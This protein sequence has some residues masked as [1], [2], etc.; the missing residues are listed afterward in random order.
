MDEDTPRGNDRRSV[1]LWEGSRHVVWRGVVEDSDDPVVVKQP[2]DQKD[3]DRIRNEAAMGERLRGLPGVREVLGLEE[4]ARGPALRLAWVDGETLAQWREERN[5]SLMERLAMAESV[6]RILAGVH[7][8]DVVHRDLSASNLLVEKRGD[9]QLIDLGLATARKRAQVDLTGAADLTGTLRYMAPEQTGRMNRPVDSRSDLYALGGV[10]YELFTGSPPF[11]EEDPLGLIHAH[12]ARTP[13]PADEGPSRVPGSIARILDKLL[14]K[15]PEDR[16]QTARGLAADLRR[17]IERLRDSGHIEPF[18]VGEEDLSDQLH[19]PDRLYGRQ[20]EIERIV[21]AYERMATGGR[22]LLLVAGAPG[23]G[24]SALVR[25]VQPAVTAR[26]GLFAQ[27]KFDQ[28]QRS[29]PFTALT[30]AFTSLCRVILGEPEAAFESWRARLQGALGAIGQVAVDLV[31][32]LEKIVGPQPEV[33][34]LEGHAAENRLR[35]LL[36]RLVSA[37]AGPEHPLLLFIDDVQWTGSASL[38]LLEA[39]LLDPELD[40]LLVVG[41]YRDSEVDE[42]HIIT[43]AQET[44]RSKG[45]EIETVTLGDLDLPA[46][47]ELVSETVGAGSEELAGVLHAKTAGNPFFAHRLLSR[48]ADEGHLRFDPDGRRWR[49]DLGAIRGLPSS[50]NVVD[51]LT[52][53]VSKLPEQA[54]G[55]LEL[56][57][58]IGDRFEI[59]LLTGLHEMSSEDAA[60]ELDRAVAAGFVTEHLGTYRFVHDRIQHAAH[61]RMN[62]EERAGAHLRI[63]RALESESRDEN[64]LA[65]ADHLGQATSLLD[66]DERLELAEMDLHAAR[67][68]GRTAAFAA[69]LTY[70]RAGLDLLGEDAW[71]RHYRLTLAL[72]EQAALQA[73]AAGNIAA[74]EQHSE[75]VLQ[76]GRDPLDLARVQRLRIEFLSSSRCFDEA[77]EYGLEALRLL[78]QEFPPEPD[79]EFTVA[80]LSGL[81]E[82]LEREPPDYLSMPRLHDQDPEL[83]AVSELLFPVGNAAFISRPALAPLMFL[84]SLELSIERRLLPEHAP[85]V[86]A[87]VGM[88][89][90]AFLEKVEVAHAYGGTA[91]ELASRAAFHT[92]SHVP[93]QVHGLYSHFWREPLRETL[94]LFD[95]GIQSAHDCGDNEFVAYMSHSWSKHALESRNASSSFVL[96][97]TASNTLPRAGGPT[98]M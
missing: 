78:G 81:I 69:G 94:D 67:A 72:H 38:G 89:A 86:I 60:R 54:R 18:P 49:W 93:L 55:L 52:L 5:P 50:D 92:F 20:A 95:R 4:G 65:I 71:E 48:M 11:T 63:G 7:D 42:T 74:M 84:R 23:V 10:L 2:I 91:V 21:A 45:L 46:L 59:G 15:D 85:G 35:Y 22:E 56:G 57:S 27:G 75:Q 73:H 6:A 3:A 9:V 83:H 58:C 76:R 77:I 19:I 33:P 96:L 39:L 66:E 80:E 29:V 26:G 34:A 41:A 82:R 98:S 32:A 16:Y 68:A 51:L 87:V 13:A 88:F 62:P 64:L 12:I 70:A 47:T 79:M 1:K 40:G 28:Y 25:E 17:C 53:Q 30:Q 24:K 44:L 61:S 8:R 97:L 43:T 14:A 37:M 36:A 31:P 90:H